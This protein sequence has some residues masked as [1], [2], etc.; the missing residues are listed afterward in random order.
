MKANNYKG[1]SELYEKIEKRAKYVKHPKFTGN[2]CD[3]LT[4]A[5]NKAF[6]LARYQRCIF[7][8]EAKNNSPHRWRDKFDR[9]F[10]DLQN[11]F[12]CYYDMELV[13]S[14]E[15]LALEEI[16]NPD[17]GRNRWTSFEN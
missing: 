15:N 3:G 5:L 13:A 17:G 2:L 14:G 8:W 12:R 4:A 10:S 16:I 6:D 9:D 11:W 7:N 1:I